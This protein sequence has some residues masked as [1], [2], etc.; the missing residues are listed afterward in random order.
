MLNLLGVYSYNS[1]GDVCGEVDGI[2]SS[3]NDL[4]LSHRFAVHIDLVNYGILS[5]IDSLGI[6]YGEVVKIE[7]IRTGNGQTVLDRVVL[8][9]R[10]DEGKEVFSVGAVA[11]R[12]GPG[13]L[14]RE[15]LILAEIHLKIMPAGL[16]E[17]IIYLIRECGR[18]GGQY[19]GL[20]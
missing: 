3:G 4:A 17:G 9:S 16:V 7:S 5:V 12:E 6:I 13:I 11:V 14:Q 18:H 8:C 20:I 19:L 10:K 15:F 1:V 2:G